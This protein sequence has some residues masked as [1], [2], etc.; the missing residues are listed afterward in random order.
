M[1]AV[2]QDAQPLSWAFRFQ[3]RS[4]TGCYMIPALGRT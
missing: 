3:I 1:P 4:R 2:I